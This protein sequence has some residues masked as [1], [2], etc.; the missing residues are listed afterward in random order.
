MLET[1]KILNKFGLSYREASEILKSDDLFDVFQ[2]AEENEETFS[3][4]IRALDER[5]ADYLRTSAVQSA[6]QS[7]AKTPI[8]EATEEVVETQQIDPTQLSDVETRVTDIDDDFLADLFGDDTEEAKEGIEEETPPVV[9]STPAQAPTPAPEPSPAPAPLPKF[10]KAVAKEKASA[11][12]T[13]VGN[14]IPQVD[15]EGFIVVDF[16][17]G[18]M[19]GKYTDEFD[20]MGTLYL[21]KASMQVEV[22]SPEATDVNTFLVDMVKQAGLKMQETTD[23]SA[24][25]LQ[26]FPLG[27]VFNTLE[28]GPANMRQQTPLSAVTTL[29]GRANRG[30]SITLGTGT[31]LPPYDVW[32]SNYYVAPEDLYGMA[33]CDEFLSAS[34][35]SQRY[36]TNYCEGN[37]LKQLRIFEVGGRHLQVNESGTRNVNIEDRV[38]QD[39][40][41]LREFSGRVSALVG[42]EM[43]RLEKMYNV[44]FVPDY[45]VGYEKVDEND[46]SEKGGSFLFAHPKTSNL[47]YIPAVIYNYFRKFYGADVV[48]GSGTPKGGQFVVAFGDD[49]KVGFV[50]VDASRV[51][52]AAPARL[53]P[54]DP[55]KEAD[56]IYTLHMSAFDDF[57]NIKDLVSELKFAGEEVVV[58][59][60]A[61]VEE[62]KVPDVVVE[63]V[64]EADE[65][66]AKALRDE[67]TE[68]RET[69]ALF[70]VGEDDDLIEELNDA[71]EGLE[72]VLEDYDEE[73]T[74]EAEIE[75]AEVKEEPET[76][77][78]E[79]MVEPDPEP[80]PE[81]EVEDEVGDDDLDFLD[82]AKGGQT[83]DDKVSDKIRLLRKE[84]KPQ[85][86]AVAIALS[87]RD[88]NEL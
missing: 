18:V 48:S 82:F 58:E 41:D 33:D 81:A 71:I 51:S 29:V 74:M 61:E 16:M 20:G 27:D 75:V 70:E 85:D 84:G 1:K 60:V 79:V 35:A 78:E 12:F 47:F 76:D 13:M 50:L 68:L 25:S 63:E 57:V 3:P 40:N 4:V 73:P 9:V 2:E 55:K 80:E 28:Y 87:M 72:I 31:A 52:V 39:G 46:I 42:D 62:T 32:R 34:V 11:F 44:G 37:D 88:R 14:K 65:D 54:E 15:S 49:V 67:I 22:L 38:M 21:D 36:I 23:G 77:V 86:Q 66:V 8:V 45:S 26:R 19:R 5:V 7:N 10:Y 24:L 83:M 6:L 69:I 17:S 59:E 30:E 43:G 56:D 64:A 53:L